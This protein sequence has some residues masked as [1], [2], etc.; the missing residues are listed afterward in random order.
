M[1]SR[2]RR[3]DVLEA[4]EAR[5]A[6]LLRVRPALIVCSGELK[7]TTPPPPPVEPDA[8]RAAAA[9]AASNTEL[10]GRMAENQKARTHTHSFGRE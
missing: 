6:L 5:R 1:E 7:Q 8:V 10:C 2:P 9:A 4:P 3:K